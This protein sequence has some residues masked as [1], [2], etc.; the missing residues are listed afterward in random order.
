MA[1][2]E[3]GKNHQPDNSSSGNNSRKPPDAPPDLDQ[4]LKDLQQKIK[5]FFGV[6]KPSG[7]NI[8]EQ[9]QKKF[10]S[11]YKVMAAPIGIFIVIIL[12]VVW[13]LSGFYIVEPAEKA[14]VLR[15]GKYVGTENPGL[16]WIPP[17]IETRYVVNV[18]QV[19]SYS[20]HAEMLTE[21]ENIVLVDL[22][23]QYRI[24]DLKDFLFNGAN[25]VESLQQATASALRQ[26]IGQT[27]LDDILTSGREKVRQQTEEI[28]I[29][30]LNRY[31][32]GLI[33]ADV[34]MQPAKPPEE[35]TSAFDD[36]IKAREDEK[37]FINQSKAYANRVVPVAQGQVSRLMAEADAYKQQ[38]VLNATAATTRFL[39]LLPQYLQSPKV[40]RERMYIDALQ[41]VFTQSSK[42]VV[43][44]PPGNNNMMVLP[45]DKI[46]QKSNT[47]AAGQNESF[48]VQSQ[49]SEMPEQ[50]NSSPPLVQ[51]QNPNNIQGK[52]T[53]FDYPSRPAINQSDSTIKGE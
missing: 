38:V 39:A 15:F 25:P 9:P 2:N 48:Q 6:K 37:R 51:T 21:D 24:R 35:V 34:N 19:L 41:S 47:Q 11:G 29:N 23:V 40:T 1:W 36:A 33:I 17:F 14:A 16:H 46:L 42:I 8:Y 28:L 13:I 18:Q 43:D 27:N 26:V 30:T 4:V 44:T 7:Q 50:A 10:P 31:Q 5:N 22:T 3:P 52:T 53:G 12:T 20:Y 49:N 45:L 32:L